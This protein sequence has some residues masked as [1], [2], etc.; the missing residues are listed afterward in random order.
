MARSALEQA[1]FFLPT[2]DACR[3]AGA[4]GDLNKFIEEASTDSAYWDDRAP[5]LARGTYSE[6]T[7]WL[8]PVIGLRHAAQFMRLARGLR[9]RGALQLTTGRE[10]VSLI[11]IMQIESA[12]TAGVNRYAVTWSFDPNSV[13]QLLEGKLNE[14]VSAE[15]TF[16]YKWGISFA[17]SLAV[18]RPSSD[19]PELDFSLARQRMVGEY[20]SPIKITTYGYVVAPDMDA[21]LVTLNPVA[22][23]TKGDSLEPHEAC[24]PISP[25]RP[26]SER[27][28]SV[29]PPRAFTQLRSLVCVK[30]P[31]WIQTCVP[32]PCGGS[33]NKRT[34]HL[35]TPSG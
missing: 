22:F 23:G 10:A 33:L 8:H 11:R 20:L 7:V 17:I 16:V 19:S 25:S 18:S 34:D 31:S 2:S 28:A 32:D 5:A 1:S 4:C 26:S 3:L 35:G 29:F 15:V 13:T 12:S 24:E 27:Q 9:L 21:S 14:V 30:E 6:T